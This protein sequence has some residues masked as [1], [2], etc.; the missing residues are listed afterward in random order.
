MRAKALLVMVQYHLTFSYLSHHADLEV[1]TFVVR[2]EEDEGWFFA[3]LEEAVL[4]LCRSAS[5]SLEAATVKVETTD[6]TGYEIIDPLV[7]QTTN[8]FIEV[9]KIQDVSSLLEGITVSV[10]VG[11]LML[12]LPYFP[13]FPLLLP[14]LLFSTSCIEFP[15]GD[16]EAEHIKR[17]TPRRRRWSL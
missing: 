11:R 5:K 9:N 12:S 1:E 13:L 7:R 6:M 8:L 2:G 3:T 16:W 4:E 15:R 14:V 17:A 10:D